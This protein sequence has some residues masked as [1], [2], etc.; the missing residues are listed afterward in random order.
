MGSMTPHPVDL[1]RPRAPDTPNEQNIIQYK[2]FRVL[3]ASRRPADGGRGP[4]RKRAPETPTARPRG[5]R[6]PTSE[7]R[8]GQGESP[9]E[10]SLR[11]MP[12]PGQR[13]DL[14]FS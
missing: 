13:V 3:K 6:P 4:S 12:C 9:T 11:T 14:V 1:F 2:G 5:S 10:G 8:R 7:Q